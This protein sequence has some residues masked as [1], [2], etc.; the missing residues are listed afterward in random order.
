MI[1]K[2][3]PA[4]FFRFFS[5]VRYLFL[6]VI[7][8]IWT[9]TSVVFL[10]QW[11]WPQF[12]LF[13]AM[14]PWCLWFAWFALAYNKIREAFWQQLAT[15]YGWEYSFTK[16]LTAEKA[17]LFQMGHSPAVHNGIKGSYNDM[18][19]HIFEYD[20]TVGS[21]KHKSIH[22]FTVFEIKFTGTFPHLYLNYK[23]DSYSNTPSMFSSIAKVSLPRDFENEFKLYVPKE[24]EIEA[25]EIFT[26]DVFSVLIDLKWDYDME[27]ADGELVIYRKI[28]FNSFTDLD[29][30]LDRIKKIVIILSPL[31]NRL[32]LAQIGDI[33]PLLKN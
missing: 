30:E 12:R 6:F 25:L 29:R 2:T 27:F 16:D 1:M 19:F 10:P 5:I 14:F 18:P 17:L 20:Y 13:V 23:N 4:K 15:K 26:P 33:S 11:F 24:Y 22:S 28:K 32:K 8:I 7:S 31:L 3:G 21:G 9:I